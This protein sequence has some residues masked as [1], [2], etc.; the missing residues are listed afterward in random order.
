MT[1]N[2]CS[3]ASDS[4]I[5]FLN[6]STPDNR[7]RMYRDYQ[8]FA[9]EAATMHFRRFNRWFAAHGSAFVSEDAASEAML[10]FIEYVQ[11]G[12][13][14]ASAWRTST[15]AC[16]RTFTKSRLIDFGKAE[17]RRIARNLILDSDDV[18]ASGVRDL[19]AEFVHREMAEMLT[20]AVQDLPDRDREVFHHFVAGASSA[21]DAATMLGLTVPQVYERS[22]AIKTRLRRNPAL[23][24]AFHSRSEHPAAAVASAL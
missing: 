8:R 19:H 10:K 21:A 17:A 4:I 11:R 6:I 22:R 16:L 12:G 2:S 15:I 3:I 1:S 13:L 23:R 20:H 14:A 24:Q 9:V 7:L 18:L 5:A